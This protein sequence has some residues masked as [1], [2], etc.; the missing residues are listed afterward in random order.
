MQFIAGEISPDTYVNV[1]SQYRPYGRA[2]T[3][4]A[5]SRTV[6]ATEM[7]DAFRAAHDAGLQRLAR[8]G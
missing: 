3:E 7:E 6:N 8:P 5:I 2:M 1:M 4:K